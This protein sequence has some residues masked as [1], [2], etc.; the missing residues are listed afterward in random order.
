MSKATALDGESI[1]GNELKIEKAKPRPD[2]TPKQDN[3]FQDKK[4]SFGKISH[5]S[6]L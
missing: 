1:D 2:H 5:T 4:K 3:K 6:T